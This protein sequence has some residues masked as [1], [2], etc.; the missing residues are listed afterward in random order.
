MKN[1]LSAVIL[2]ACL[3]R[4]C[5]PESTR[6]E[7]NYPTEVSGWQQRHERGLKI[8]GNFVLRK[9]QM[10][11]NG[12]I[13]IKLLELIPGNPCV[14]AGSERHQ[15]RVTLQ[16]VKARDEKVLCE[17]TFAEKGSRVFSGTQ[18]RSSLTEFGIM[19]IYVIAV[20]V[21]DEWVFFELRG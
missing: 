21:K 8:L 18:C 5:C 2:L 7:P 11:E 10:I 15:P 14:D 13:Q 16:F 3:T 9:D 20:N 17:D 6:I 4:G 1:L 19:G 12:E